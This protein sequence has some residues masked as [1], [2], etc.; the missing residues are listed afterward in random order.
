VRPGLRR[1]TPT[2][3]DNENE[4]GKRIPLENAAQTP[5]DC[6]HQLGG[7]WA[8]PYTSRLPARAVREVE[9]YQ[10]LR[11][12]LEAA[13]AWRARQPIENDAGCEG[14]RKRDYRTSH[15]GGASGCGHHRMAPTGRRIRE[16]GLRLESRARGLVRGRLFLARLSAVQ[17]RGPEDQRHVLAVENRPESGAR[18][19]GDAGIASG[20][21]GSLSRM[22]T[23]FADH[24]ITHEVAKNHRTKK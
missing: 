1:V 9:T 11:S 24:S 12:I 10:P 5:R 20:R 6:I 8:I 21:V 2:A 23:W 13:L 18:P 3:D 16:P 14:E 19:A 15:G 17:S 22:G 7:F 4:N